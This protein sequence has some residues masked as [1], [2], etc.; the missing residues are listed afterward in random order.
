[1]ATEP[2]NSEETAKFKRDATSAAW[3][4]YQTSRNKAARADALNAMAQA[5]DR[6]ELSRPAL[7]AYDA[8]LNLVNSASVRAAYEDL[9]ARK[10]FRIVDHSVDNDNA[11]PRI[12]AQFS[13]EL[14]KSGTDYSSFVTL[15]A[16]RQRLLK[17]RIARFA[18][19]VWNMA[20][21]IA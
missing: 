11:S 21:H 10:G 8:S 2:S 19:K 13:E 18:S 1:M 15:T 17:P 6:R 4:G 5:L 9:K 7:Q 14:V 16:P 12:C 20:A 3:N